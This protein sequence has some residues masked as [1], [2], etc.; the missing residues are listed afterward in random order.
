MY[1]Y[2]MD[3]GLVFN[4]PPVEQFQSSRYQLFPPAQ[5]RSAARTMNIPWHT[6]YCCCAEH[7]FSPILLPMGLQRLRF[8]QHNGDCQIL[9][10]PGNIP[11]VLEF[12]LSLDKHNV[13]QSTKALINGCWHCTSRGTNKGESMALCPSI[14]DPNSGWQCGSDTPGLQRE[15]WHWAFPLS[16]VNTDTDR[17]S[18]KHLSPGP[19]GFSCLFVHKQVQILSSLHLPA[20]SLHTHAFFFSLNFS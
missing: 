2:S 15:G 20:S 16:Y 3:F 19:E 9:G 1:E 17:G 10:F 18:R 12:C 5:L 13:L 11:I 6:K 8:P 14:L 7:L 4:F